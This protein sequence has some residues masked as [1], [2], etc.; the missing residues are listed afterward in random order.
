MKKIKLTNKIY[1][2]YKSINED[3]STGTAG[4]AFELQIPENILKPIED[5]I[6]QEIYNDNI[7]VRVKMTK[8]FYDAMSFPTACTELNRLVEFVDFPGYLKDL[9]GRL[10]SDPKINIKQAPDY[11]AAAF[12][13]TEFNIFTAS[14]LPKKSN[15][16]IEYNSNSVLNE[17][18]PTMA[19][20]GQAAGE[21]GVM[22]G[23]GVA[24]GISGF[25]STVGPAIGNAAVSAAP[26]I[27]L[28]IAG[29]WG[30]GYATG[31]AVGTLSS[32]QNPNRF[33]NDKQYDIDYTAIPEESKTTSTDPTVAI[34]DYIRN[35]QASVSK[36]LSYITARSARQDIS[37]LEKTINTLTGKANKSIEQ[38]IRDNNETFK[39]KQELERQQE[40]INATKKKEIA[41][42]KAHIWSMVAR[43][44]LYGQYATQ[45]KKID[46][47]KLI[48]LQELEKR[49]SNYDST[50]SKS[51]SEAIRNINLFIN[52]LNESD[53]ITSSDNEKY[54]IF[55]VD[56][57][58]DDIKTT[59]TEKVIKILSTDPEDWESIKWARKE[60]DVMQEGAD[61][62]ILA[63]I[64]IICRTGNVEQ[65]GL[66]AK[67]G[68][69]IHKHPM[70]A[71]YL[72]GLWGRYRTFNYTYVSTR[73]KS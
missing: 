36:L 68:A 5:S 48:S 15:E 52:K 26:T 29:L 22:I 34:D 47:M 31:T 37:D 1:S 27:G 7:F 18:I 13:N 43:N 63:K 56:P 65:M 40:T 50:P 35:I 60:M 12:T 51:T 8:N 19:Q 16:S 54:L 73:W 20:V 64:D 23:Q 58:Y 24:D 55:N 11:A 66:G 57:I 44:N 9:G 30:A 28:G 17:D 38:F 10:D 67:L 69:F 4:A 3:T 71:E 70:R 61:K 53:A 25:A 59:L 2:Q 49:L 62:E 72:K 33:T 39:E 42:I 21:L 46:S 14:P 45:L 32:D 6:E 41:D